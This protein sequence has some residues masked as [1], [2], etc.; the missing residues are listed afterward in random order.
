MGTSSSKFCYRLR[1]EKFLGNLQQFTLT[2]SPQGPQC[3]LTTQ[4]SAEAA[5]SSCNSSTKGG[6]TFQRVTS[7]EPWDKQHFL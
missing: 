3:C 6:R 1:A 7:R 2:P 4:I 5:P